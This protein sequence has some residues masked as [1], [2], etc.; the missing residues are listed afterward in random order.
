MEQ[1]RGGWFWTVLAGI[2]VATIPPVLLYW[3]G[4]GR[5]T[6]SSH[7]L[8]LK[9]NDKSPEDLLQPGSIWVGT[10]AKREKEKTVYVKKMRLVIT[11]RED[12]NFTGEIQNENELAFP[13]EG[14]IEQ[15]AIVWKRSLTPSEKGQGVIHNF[16]TGILTRDRFETQ[17]VLREGIWYESKFQLV[18]R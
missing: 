17:R 11:R 1:G 12:S 16:N 3:F 9:E 15:N 4:I 6:P 5:P 13:I 18:A 8:V 7:V 14:K 10:Q 2:L